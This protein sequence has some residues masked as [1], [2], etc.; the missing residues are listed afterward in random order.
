MLSEMEMLIDGYPFHPPGKPD[1]L[2][3]NHLQSLAVPALIIQG[4][5]DPFGTQEDVARYSLSPSIRIEWLTGGDHSFKPRAA[6]GV[7]S[8]QNL[9]RAVALAAM[10]IADH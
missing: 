9:A 10:F 6:S 1:R 2:R 3:T 4:E 8:E 5:R 7:T